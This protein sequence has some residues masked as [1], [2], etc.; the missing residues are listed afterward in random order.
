[1]SDATE[2]YRAAGVDLVLGNDVSKMLYEAAKHTWT[3]RIGRLGELAE[4]GT[5]FSSF[6]GMPLT[7]IG[8][9]DYILS[10]GADGVGTKVEVAERLGDHR[11]IGHDLVAM[12][13]DDA[14]VR[15][16]E[17]FAVATV[18]DVRAL[19][20]VDNLHE[21]VRQLAS[22]YIEAAKA[23]DVTIVN[24]E[25]AE[26]GSRVGGFNS[27]HNGFNYNWS[28]VA[29]WMVHKSRII[30]DTQIRPGDS[31]VALRE[32]GFRSNGLSLV[33]RIFGAHNEN[34]HDQNVDP[35]AEPLAQWQKLGEL[36]LKPSIIYSKAVADMTGGSDISREAKARV[37]GAAHITGGGIPEKLGR[38]LRN[39]GYG[40][41]LDDLYEPP[42]VMKHAQQTHITAGL[43]D[44][45]D[46]ACYRTWN[47]GQ[48]MLIVSPE[49]ESVID[50]AQSHGIQSKIVGEIDDKP[51]IKLISKGHYSTGKILRFRPED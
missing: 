28:A 40:A 48:G 31:V 41:Y 30:D 4:Y 11:T 14:V 50:V 37:H 2:A 26:L 29:L 25:T 32:H 10:A 17:P 24:G 8:L 47:M 13:C 46:E 34:W 18:L 51:G 43:G 21:Q 15:G 33:R 27:D 39:T 1:M 49:P 3:D 23:A 16:G 36:V 35:T 20:E 6:R 42:Y 9:P 44:L 45:S 5:G 7:A 38:V 12:A 19:N 22:G